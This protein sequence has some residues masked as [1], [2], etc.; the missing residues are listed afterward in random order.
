[1]YRH[2]TMLTG[3]M[4]D[5]VYTAHFSNA[6]EAYEDWKRIVEIVTNAPFKGVV[7]AVRYYDGHPMSVKSVCKGV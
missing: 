2:E 4:G 7:T 5:T 6:N 3:V 1:M